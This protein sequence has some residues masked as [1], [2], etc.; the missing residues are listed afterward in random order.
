M[1]EYQTIGARGVSGARSAQ[2]DEGL[3]AH[4]NK[5]YALMSGALLMTFALAYLV[6]SSPALQQVLLVS[7]V[8]WVVIFG[9][10]A[11]VLI[12]SFAFHKLSVVA[13]NALFWAYAALTGVSLATIFIM[14]DMMQVITGLAYTAVAFLGLSLTGYLTKRNLG[15]IHQ[16]A[17]MMVWGL[18]AFAL[19]SMLFGGMGGNAFWWMN[20]AILGLFAVL[21]ATSTQ[22]IKNT[23]LEARTHGGPEAQLFLEKA[24]II[25]AL[26]LYISFIAMFR[27]IMYLFMGGDD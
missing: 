3:R 13:L 7:P 2:I 14:F 15:P 25:G 19:I 4:M 12:A 21:T 11:F 6:A 8:V 5:V 1:A 16:V 17:V 22:E 10:L 20:V 9:P 24:A 23:Y 26:Q 18:V 27:S